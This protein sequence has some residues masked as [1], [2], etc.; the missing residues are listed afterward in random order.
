MANPNRVGFVPL[1]GSLSSYINGI[2][3]NCACQ[4]LERF[5]TLSNLN[6]ATPVDY[7]DLEFTRPAHKIKAVNV[8]D[9]PKEIFTGMKAYEDAARGMYK[10]YLLLYVVQRSRSIIVA[11]TRFRLVR[12]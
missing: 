5:S 12:F 10:S 2:E 11:I 4:V 3:P 8:P 1:R 6:M 7:G 9:V